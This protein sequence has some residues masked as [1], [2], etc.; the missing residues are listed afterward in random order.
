MNGASMH[1][2]KESGLR[3]M[4]RLQSTAVLARSADINVGSAFSV[5]TGH[6]DASVIEV[7]EAKHLASLAVRFLLQVSRP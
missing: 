7:S 4:A 3:T 2:G 6:L 5:P 1:A